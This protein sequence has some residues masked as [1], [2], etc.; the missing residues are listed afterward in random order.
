MLARL[1]YFFFGVGAGGGLLGV[2]FVTLPPTESLVVVGCLGALGLGAG[3]GDV[4]F[5]SAIIFSVV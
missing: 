4:G 3:A 2:T 1:P 5:F